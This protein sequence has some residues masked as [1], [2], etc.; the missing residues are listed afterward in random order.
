VSRGPSAIAEFLIEY[1]FMPEQIFEQY[2]V[3][4]YTF[5]KCQQFD[6]SAVVILISFE[7]MFLCH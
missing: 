5:N 4:L 1:I 2:H 3:V 7:N 6:I